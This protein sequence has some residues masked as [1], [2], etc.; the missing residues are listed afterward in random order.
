MVNQ[1]S[2]IYVYKITTSLI[3]IMVF[4]HAPSYFYHQL[5]TN[6]AGPLFKYIGSK[7]LRDIA[8]SL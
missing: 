4:I 2:S 1:L 8:L 3:Q 6:L 7:H 5:W